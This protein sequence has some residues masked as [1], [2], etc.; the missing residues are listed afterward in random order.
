ML[1]QGEKRAGCSRYRLGDYRLMYL[2]DRSSHRLVVLNV[3]HR[4]DVC[5]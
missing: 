5:R 4:R 1:H 2:L 3:G